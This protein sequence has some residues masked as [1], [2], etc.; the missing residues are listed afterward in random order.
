M[1]G[2]TQRRVPLESTTLAT[3][4]YDEHRCALQLDFRDGARYQSDRSIGGKHAFRAHAVH[5]G[6]DV[7]PQATT[8]LVISA[9]PRVISAA[10]VLYPKSIPNRTPAAMATMF[11]KAPPSST[12]M[13]SSLVYTRKLGSL[14]SRCTRA[15]SS[16]SDEAMV[17][18]VGSP[19]ATSL[20][21]VGPLMAPI[22][23]TKPLA[24][25]LNSWVITSVMRSR[26]SFSIPLVALTNS[27]S[28]RSCGSMA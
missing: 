23:G 12:P 4:G 7:F 15:A 17:M 26:E 28:G 21:N 10:T 19:F 16:L 25:P 3:A 24:A 6:D 2:T 5:P 1:T 13:T 22:R 11:F 20:A 18:A 14:N 9:S 8:S 27:I